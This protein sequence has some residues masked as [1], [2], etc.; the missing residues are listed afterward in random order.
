M[1]RLLVMRHGQTNYNVRGLCN[2]DPRADVHLTEL[3]IRQ[4]EA[5]AHALREAP[6]ERILVS[7]LPRTR[8]TAEI[9]NRHHGVPVDVQD[10]LN[11]IRSGFDGRPVRDYFAAVGS[12]RYRIRPAGG[13]S[14]HEFQARVLPLFDWLEPK[15]WRCVLA[16][17]HEETMRVLAA[18]QRGLDAHAMLGLNFANCEVLAMDLQ[19]KRQDDARRGRGS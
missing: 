19:P 16:V 17:T 11:D 1:M 8:Q 14:V 13:E 12:D 5:A 6:I 15:P 18:A 10:C 7:A 9:I 3:G 4:A 2:D